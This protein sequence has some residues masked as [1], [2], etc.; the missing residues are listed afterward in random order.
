MSREWRCTHSMNIANV[1]VMAIGVAFKSSLAV[2]NGI[3]KLREKKL[4]LPVVL[5]LALCGGVGYLSH[6]IDKPEL[7]NL[8]AVIVVFPLAIAIGIKHNRWGRVKINSATPLH[9]P[10]PC[11]VVFGKQGKTYCLQA[12]RT[13]RACSGCRRRGYG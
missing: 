4:L 10:K 7:L 9:R 13:R 2:I 12:R 1:A 11:G 6:K 3:G 5:M 8:F